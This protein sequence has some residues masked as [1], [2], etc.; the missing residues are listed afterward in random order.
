MKIILAALLTLPAVAFAEVGVAEIRGT[1]PDSKITGTA[2]FE[3]T[4]A[5][6]KVS[7]TIKGA[8]GDHALH[9]HEFGDC[10]DSG[11]NAGGHYNPEKHEHG[12]A[13]KD[14]KKAHAGDLGNVTAKDG[15]IVL[16]A[17]LPRTSL[18]EGKH[19]VAGR[20]VVLH[21]K[22]DDFSQP[23]GSAGARAACGVITLVGK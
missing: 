14:A 19:N 20:S 7:V 13:L 23:T 8:E 22:A 6:L 15:V 11:K 4:K 5:G 3:E 17:T 21:E 12:N 10:G 16:E 1:A 2:R 9:I 18:F